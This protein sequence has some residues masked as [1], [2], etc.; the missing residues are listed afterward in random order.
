[1]GSVVLVREDNCPR[2]QWS[3]GVIEELIKGRD[4]VNRTEKVKTKR[5]VSLA[6]SREFMTWS[7]MHIKF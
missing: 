7:C 4:G 3:I 2:L 1:M 5:A 6:Q